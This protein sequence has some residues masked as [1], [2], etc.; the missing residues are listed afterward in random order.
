MHI[1]FRE[2]KNMFSRPVEYERLI[3]VLN[4]TAWVCVDGCVRKVTPSYN[5]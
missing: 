1:L 5:V 3:N 4:N 2:V